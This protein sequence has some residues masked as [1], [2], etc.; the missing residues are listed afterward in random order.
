MTSEL[1]R[2]PRIALTMGDP[3]GIGP[4]LCL[5]ALVD[6]LIKETCIPIIFGD[7]E[8]LRRC[9]EKVELPAPMQVISEGD[10]PSRFGELT[11]PAV[12]DLQQIDAEQ[13]TPGVVDAATGTASY[14][15]IQSAITAALAGEVAA[16]CT[17]PISKTAIHA[18][19]VN[20]PGHTEMF[21]ARTNA[22]RSCMMQ[23]S[24][25][26]TCTFVTVHVGYAE[27]P[28]LLSVQ[29]ILEVIELTADAMRRLHSR[30]PR[31]VVCGLNPHAGENGLFGDE[32]QR[33]IIPAIAVAREQGL[34]VEGPLPPDT[35]FLPWKRH[36]TDAFVCMYH[37]Q[38]HIPV[39]AL[40]FDS[41]VNTTLGLPI[42]RTSVD[43][44][45]ACDI[46]WQGKANPGSLYNAL[47]LAA[48][49]A[50]HSR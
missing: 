3:A 40:A 37:D 10:W 31:L 28:A 32:E 23:F 29:R 39:K 22:A 15:Y 6:P 24:P 7:I 11:S 48:R 16:V 4:E 18:A 5:R 20:F 27:V 9:A 12:L 26:I 49:L 36:I 43:H 34:S 19:G 38:G 30:E 45:T 47:R 21:A 42:I 33:L 46:A 17:S 35:A 44:G 13:V 41:A 25:Q 8:V 1:T 50:A 2:L 14:A